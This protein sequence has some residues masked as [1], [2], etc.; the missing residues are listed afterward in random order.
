MQEQLRAM[1]E[2]LRQSELQKKKNETVE[3]LIKVMSA[4]YDKASTFTN[5]IMIGGYASF[6]A[7]WGKMYDKLSPFY[8]GLSGAF[9]TLSVLFF[10]FWEIHKLIFYSTNLKDFYQVTEEENPERFFDKLNKIRLEEQ[11]KSLRQVKIWYFV[12]IVTIIP[13]VTGAGIFIVHF[14]NYLVKSMG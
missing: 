10:I 4:S 14:I 5:V 11:R 1:G 6:F 7:V 9:V 3:T 12:L 2:F 13:G 8:M